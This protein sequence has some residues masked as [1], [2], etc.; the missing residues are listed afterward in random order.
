[1]TDNRKYIEH[2][3]DIIAA[4]NSYAGEAEGRQELRN[5]LNAAIIA[6][7]EQQENYAKKGN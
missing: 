3:Q 6:L 1:M 2:L 7:Q 4:T 5:T